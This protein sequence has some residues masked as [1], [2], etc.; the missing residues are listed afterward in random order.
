MGDKKRTVDRTDTMPELRD[1]AHGANKGI[2]LSVLSKVV[3]GTCEEGQD[4][5]IRRCGES[6]DEIDLTHRCENCGADLGS[7]R[8][9]RKFCSVKCRNADYLKIQQAARREDRKGRRCVICNGD[10]PLE[11][12]AGTLFCSAKCHDSGAGKAHSLG[13]SKKCEHCGSDFRACK[14]SQRF[15]SSRCK[16]ESSRRPD[17]KCPSCRRMFY[18]AHYRQVFCSHSCSARYRCATG[19][20]SLHTKCSAHDCLKKSL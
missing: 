2:L 18:P 1:D 3:R 8:S 19:N 16:Y 7:G 11:K 17:R 13:V 12:R 10:I 5:T 14:K 6:R 20:C 15:C 9:D 4:E